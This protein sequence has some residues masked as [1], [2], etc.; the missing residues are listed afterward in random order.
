MSKFIGAAM[1]WAILCV[2]AWLILSGL[3]SFAVLDW[4]AVTGNMFGRAAFGIV[5]VWLAINVYGALN[6]V[7]AHD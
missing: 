7:S 4:R 5:C 3:I 1:A 6:K 2:G